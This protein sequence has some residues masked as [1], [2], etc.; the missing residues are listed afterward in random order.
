MILTSK[1]NFGLQE[2]KKILPGN[3]LK[4]ELGQANLEHKDSSDNKNLNKKFTNS[5]FKE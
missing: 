1:M 4:M 5:L 2:S 3:Q